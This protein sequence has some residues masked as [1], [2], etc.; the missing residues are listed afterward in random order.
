MMVRLPPKPSG[1]RTFMR[2]R[3]TFRLP[4]AGLM[5]L[6]AF[7]PQSLSGQTSS[8]RPVSTDGFAVLVPFETQ[9][10]SRLTLRLPM[11]T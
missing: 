2:T 8:E 10:T 6:A 7:A 5:F 9:P 3:A 11:L 1:V 4:L